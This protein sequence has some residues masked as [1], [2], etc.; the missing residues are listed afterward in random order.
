MVPKTSNAPGCVVIQL[1]DFQI[2]QEMWSKHHIKAL[3]RGIH[4]DHD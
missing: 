2:S 3:L 1:T 4:F